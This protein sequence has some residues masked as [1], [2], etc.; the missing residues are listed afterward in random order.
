MEHK[1]IKDAEP[2]ELSLLRELVKQA[3]PALD[4]SNGDIVL[5][6]DSQDAPI[7]S[8]HKRRRSSLKQGAEATSVDDSWKVP[9]DADYEKVLGIQQKLYEQRKKDVKLMEKRERKLQRKLNECN[10]VRDKQSKSMVAMPN[11][12]ERK[13]LL[14]ETQDLL[15]QHK[16]DVLSMKRRYDR[17]ERVMKIELKSRHKVKDIK[18]KEHECK[19]M[20]QVASGDEDGNSKE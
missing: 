16:K 18:E 7:V 12:A 10:K 2:L 15:Q 17:L 20:E 6:L 11:E 19:S 3:L 4:K 13:A 1:W 9:E 14:Q 8:K 5:E